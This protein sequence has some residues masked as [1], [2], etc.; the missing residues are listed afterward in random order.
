V[1]YLINEATIPPAI[2]GFG[3]ARL[4]QAL[5][6]WG[7]PACTFWAVQNIGNT[8]KTLDYNDGQNVFAWQSGSWPGQLGDPSS[9]IGVTLPVFSNGEIYD[10]DIL[11][12]NVGFCWNDNGGNNCVDT[13]SI[14]THEDGH[15]L[16]LDHSN[17]SGATMEAFYGGGNSIAS[18]EPDDIS[19][20]CGL[21]PAQ[22]MAVS[23]SSGG[24]NNCQDCADG[25]AQNQ[26]SGPYNACGSS[27]QCVNYAN[28][29]NNCGSQSCAD[30]CGN[31]FPQGMSIY[32][33]YV[34]CVCN[35]CST[36]CAMACGGSSGPSSSSSSSGNGAS[37]SS[38][39]PGTG[40]AGGQGQGGSTGAW[41]EDPEPPPLNPTDSSSCGCSME[42][43]PIRFGAFLGAGALVLAWMRRRS[44]RA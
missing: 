40:G 7:E 26:C 33:A 1:Q 23:S 8:N 35:F 36:E 27:Q 18:I 31:Q 10:A 12:N 42:P 16:G 2:A 20:V 32:D 28:C 13:L 43:S 29:L 44:R 6:A 3:K 11:Y 19:G 17:V 14:A 34:D 39:S 22:G 25:T 38:G 41:G 37:S 4:D 24:G 9:V 5:A 21:Y 30:N 15:F